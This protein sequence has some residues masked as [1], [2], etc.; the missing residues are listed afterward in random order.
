M[1]KLYVLVRSDLP[2]NYQAVQAGHA[3]AEWCKDEAANWHWDGRDVK[4]LPWRW[5]NGTL[6]Y[7]RVKDE[8]D[9]KMW[10]RR[11]AEVK[12]VQS[13]FQ[14]PDLDY[15]MTAIAVLSNLEVDSMLERMKLV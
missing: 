5:S 15:Q 13:P 8:D 11:F 10:N 2:K 14:E 12:A 7:L 3:V 1:A 6:I 9:L 4:S